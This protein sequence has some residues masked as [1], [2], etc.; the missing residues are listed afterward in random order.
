MDQSSDDSCTA[1]AND[2]IKQMH[3]IKQKI[4][5][6]TRGTTKQVGIVIFEV[7]NPT[8]KSNDKKCMRDG[9]PGLTRRPTRVTDSATNNIHNAISVAPQV[10]LLHGHLDM[11]WSEV[12]LIMRAFVLL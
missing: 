12:L 1:F 5:A 8:H 6:V 7:E 10:L 2:S 9:S 4:N 11:V 3:T